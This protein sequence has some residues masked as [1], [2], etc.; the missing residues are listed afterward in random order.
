M[1]ALYSTAV[2]LFALAFGS[3]DSTEV[4]EEKMMFNFTSH[5]ADLLRKILSP[6]VVDDEL[7]SSPKEKMK[8][9]FNDYDDYFKRKVMTPMVLDEDYEKSPVENNRFDFANYV[10]Q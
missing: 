9:N 5:D 10:L 3:E 1:R 6:M 4:S 7:E 2:L 8:F